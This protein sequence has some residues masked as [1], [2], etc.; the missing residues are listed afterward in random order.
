MIT[1]DLS[2]HLALVTGATG[3]IG[4]ATCA[5]LSDLGCAIAVH[6]NSAVDAAET[7][8][9]EVRAKGIRAE[10]FQA[11]LSKYDEVRVSSGAPL[12]PRRR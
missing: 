1:K 9:T 2:P 10:A 3:G 5:A 7:L 11:D 12:P 8:V 6:Y 4:K